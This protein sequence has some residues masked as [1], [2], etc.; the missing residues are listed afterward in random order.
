MGV[1]C[2]CCWV[3]GWMGGGQQGKLSEKRGVGEQRVGMTIQEECCPAGKKFRGW[4]DRGG[5][6]GGCGGGEG[7]GGLQ[8]KCQ[9][10]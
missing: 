2:C 1:V 6:W 10:V 5:G 7:E 9:N 3:M 4:G 8:E